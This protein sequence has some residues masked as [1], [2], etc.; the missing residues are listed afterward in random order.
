MV[1]IRSGFEFKVRRK[2][3]EYCKSSIHPTRITVGW[4]KGDGQVRGHQN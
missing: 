3:E 4:D 1:I 2:K